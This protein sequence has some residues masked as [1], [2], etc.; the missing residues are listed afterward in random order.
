MRLI[1]LYVENFGKLKDFSY[2]FDSDL[3]CITAENGYGKSTLAE[4]IRAMLYGLP[5]GAKGK[6]KAEDNLRSRFSPWQ[7]G[8]YGGTLDLETEKGRFRVS[9]VFG[10]TP[11][12]DSFSL[13]DLQTGLESNAYGENIG[14]E[15]FGIDSASYAKSTYLPQ[16]ETGP[17][18]EN[19]AG[20]LARL[21]R[22]L[23]TS[24]DMA[25]YDEADARLAEY[26][27]K[28]RLFKGVGGLIDEAK[29][30]RAECQAD[31]D[32]MEKASALAL[33]KRAELEENTSK[34]KAREAEIGE[35]SEYIAEKENE[36]NRKLTSYKLLETYLDAVAKERGEAESIRAEFKDGVPTDAEL[37][38]A[39][40]TAALLDGSSEETGEASNAELEALRSRFGGDAPSEDELDGLSRS[41]SELKSVETDI[42]RSALP[43][44]PQTVS[45]KKP[46][47]VWFAAPCAAIAV[48]VVM[49]IIMGAL[50]LVAVLIGS[51]ALASVALLRARAE[52]AL[53]ANE[54]ELDEYKEKLARYEH[55][56]ERAELLRNSLET[57]LDRYYKGCPGGI[58]TVLGRLYTD[59]ERYF[60]LL[61]AE[62][63]RERTR[64]A[65]LSDRETKKTWIDGLLKRCGVA[66][67]DS[68]TAAV[69]TLGA[70][71][72]RLKVSEEGLAKKEKEAK[73]FAAKNQ[74]EETAPA[75][76]DLTG[77][78]Q[79]R[80]ELAEELNELKAQEGRL[81]Q[82]IL[83]FEADAELLPVLYERL[84]RLKSDIEDYEKRR[85][86]AELARKYLAD[87]KNRLSSRYLRDMEESF[88][89]SFTLISGEE[90]ASEIDAELRLS[91]REGART[92]EPVWYS[93][94]YR[95]LTSVCLRLALSDA[96]FGDEKPF[97]IL[98]D[99]FCD[100][101][102]AKLERAK[103]LLS[104]L[105]KG[106]QIIYLTC[107]SSRS[108]LA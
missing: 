91:F 84:E 90:K 102:E 26:M 19:N 108:I 68:Y 31:I 89:K 11:A 6:A 78:R 88:A 28:Y 7:G 105:A 48:G 94:G 34:A 8:V 52:K 47:A 46:G 41:L 73:D 12:K 22:L 77:K 30:A 43:E 21:S 33:E 60:V 42:A 5:M 57:K 50:W 36:Y 103:G 29:T 101:D 95:A 74:I 62:K 87:A 45:V 76:P 81:R 35:I 3:S 72:L 82:Q 25:D 85:V 107:H 27:K 63:E 79:R 10:A 97:I 37:A 24:D 71:V 58:E 18:Y 92:R 86:A 1:S 69:N 54:A 83:Q 99:P 106:R 49:S 32:E 13:T 65:H 66:V 17:L 98:D 15:L 20:I 9:R 53:K 67:G 93:A 39:R 2:R 40:E 23:D 59:S 38:S 14:L 56:T 55:K 80:S 4:F 61:F 16:Y 75:Q 100:L 64:S 70:K 96:L 104:E 44:R 51:A